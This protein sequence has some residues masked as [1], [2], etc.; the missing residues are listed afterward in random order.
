MVIAQVEESVGPRTNRPRQSLLGERAERLRGALALPG[1]ALLL[2]LVIVPFGLVIVQS[3]QS[4][5]A[6]TYANYQW[7]LNS[8][9][10]E[11]TVTTCIIALGSVGL[12]LAVAIPLALGLDRKFRGSGVLRALVT[13]PWAVPTIGVMTAFLWLTNTNYG[14]FNQVAMAS[15][16]I[17]TPIAVLSDPRFALTA[18]T[19][20]HAWKSMPLVLLVILAALQSRSVELVEAARADG[21]SPGQV[22]RHVTWPH[23][24]GAVTIGA[25]L[26][27][28][29]NF[30]L[31]DITFLLTG[32]GPS[33]RTT[34]LPLLLYSQWFGSGDVGRASAV[35]C[36]IFGASV[37]VL[38]LTG[39][40]LNRLDA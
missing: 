25:A 11:A 9:A 21:A 19:V 36:L 23:I 7:L 6:W 3:L 17:D 40:R 22:F 18:V 31:F 14:L 27:G 2:L 16:L 32:G 33:G 29:Y 26:T 13:T 20:A 10:A 15:G 30:T 38:A 34:T 5:G 4:E 35:G 1:A 39:R 37:L 8:E 28:V 12:S 24:R